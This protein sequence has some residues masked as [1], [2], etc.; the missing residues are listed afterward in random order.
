MRLLIVF[1][2]IIT[3]F[4]I[5]PP[6]LKADLIFENTT[7]S[8]TFTCSFFVNC[9]RETCPSNFCSYGDPIDPFCGSCICSE[10]DNVF[11]QCRQVGN[12]CHIND[13]GCNA[14]NTIAQDCVF[15]SSCDGD[16]ICEAGENNANCPSDCP[17]SSCAPGF[18][19]CYG[20]I[21]ACRSTSQ[22]C[23][24]H[25][26]AECG[27]PG[28]PGPCVETYTQ[29]DRCDYSCTPCQR[30]HIIRDLYTGQPCGVICVDDASCAA[31]ACSPKCGQPSICGGNCSGSDDGTPGPI[32]F[33]APTGGIVTLSGNSYTVSWSAASKAEQY[34][35]QLYPVGT[36]CASPYAYC[37]ATSSTRSYTITPNPAGGNRYTLMVRP[38]NTTC[39]AYGGNDNGSWYQQDFTIHATINGS[40]G[41]DTDGNSFL[42]N[43][44]CR[45]GNST[46]FT[47]TGNSI[48]TE[49][50]YGSYS[51]SFGSDLFGWT[52]TVSVPWWPT[53]ATPN[54]IIT[55][56]PGL[57]LGGV[58][59]ECVCPVGCA[60]SG[61]ASPQ[62]FVNFYIQEGTATDYSDGGWWQVSGGN[63]YAGSTSG[64]ALQSRIPVTTCDIDP[65]CESAIL[66]DDLLETTDSAGIAVT[67]GGSID[68]QMDGGDQT[69]YISERSPQAYVEGSTIKFQ[70]DYDYFWREFGMGTNPTSDLPNL[71]D[72]TKPDTAPTNGRAYYAI[73]TLTIQQPWTIASGEQ[74]V[75][76]VNGDLNLT[77]PVNVEQLITVDPGGFIAF[78]VSGNITVNANL[79]NDD[80]NDI[81]PNLS[82][83][84]L[85]DGMITI[86]GLG[87]SDQRFVGEGNFVGW[88]GINLYRNLDDGVGPIENNTRPAE[89]FLFRPE[90]VDRTLL[91]ERFIKSR[92]VW[93]EKI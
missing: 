28:P 36:S 77:D 34:T 11:R 2:L 91:P 38:I 55:Y 61:I 50:M 15:G 17:G 87:S 41:L 79:G 65:D 81:T 49:G 18:Q 45:D 58:P 39:S 68:S 57:T 13:L 78:I 74:L 84:Y 62:S 67:G 92:Y 52:H 59:Y 75:I 56:V 12:E 35:M 48:G 22:S 72:A 47:A 23:Q 16:G 89:L 3:G 37:P 14:G 5:F 93:Q 46:N 85:S 44:L 73:S 26:D 83:V 69:G 29:A 60:Y 6:D 40:I 19:F 21:N 80:L 86:D 24:D 1:I 66:S 4:L 31:S 9:H 71:N 54:N 33:T 51:G 27:V 82:G 53:G 25:I 63:A 32:S 10:T 42:F 88:S 43:G 20:C 30:E 76:F 7:C 90:F 64:T 8:G 70:E